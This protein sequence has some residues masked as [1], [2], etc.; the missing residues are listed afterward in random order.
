MLYCILGE[1]L[2]ISGCTI[3]GRESIML[4]CILGETLGIIIVLY[5]G[6]SL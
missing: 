2:G 3:S 1:T 6:E 5:L 4:Y